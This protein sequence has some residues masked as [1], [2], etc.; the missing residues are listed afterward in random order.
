MSSEPDVWFL[1]SRVSFHRPSAASADGM[2]VMEHWMPYG[3]SPPLHVHHEEDE[4]FHVLD[5]VMRFVVDGREAVVS[6][7]HSVVAPKGQPHT[8]RVE[9]PQGVRC[10]VMAPGQDFEGM[11]REVSRP[12]GEALPEPVTPT[13]EMQQA[14]AEACLRHRIEIL[15]PPLMA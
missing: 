4:I 10:L 11:I 6:A 1:N 9:S 14:L 5:G 12:A 2:S 3:D 15:G 7:G 8:F 13:L